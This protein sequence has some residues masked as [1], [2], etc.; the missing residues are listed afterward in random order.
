M[1]GLSGRLQSQEVVLICVDV[2]KSF[3]ER[4]LNLFRVAS[5][6]WSSKHVLY[7]VL[8]ESVS[9]KAAIFIDECHLPIFA[10]LSIFSNNSSNE[11]AD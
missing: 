11:T 5:S 4:F 7:N 10:A 9:F 1:F 2:S 6:A 8:A 3:P